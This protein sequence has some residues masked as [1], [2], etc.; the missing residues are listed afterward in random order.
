[1]FSTG[2]AC[3]CRRPAPAFFLVASPFCYRCTAMLTGVAIGVA[4]GSLLDLNI[5]PWWLLGALGCVLSMPALADV[6]AQMTYDYR[7]NIFRRSVTGVLLGLGIVCIGTLV[8][9]T[10]RVLGSI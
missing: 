7:S 10:M 8:R 4:I 1:M 5:W 9:I 2:H 3:L 6:I